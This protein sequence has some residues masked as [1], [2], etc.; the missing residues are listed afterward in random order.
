RTHI[1]GNAVSSLPSAFYCLFRS[2]LAV[3]VLFGFAFGGLTGGETHSKHTQDILFSIFCSLLLI[4]SY[5]LSR[6]SSDPTVLL[7][8]IKR[9]LLMNDIYAEGTNEAAEGEDE[10]SNGEDSEEDKSESAAHIDPLPKKLADTVTARLL[11]DAILCTFSAIVFLLLHVSGVFQT[12]QPDLSYVLWGTALLLGLLSH[13]LLPQLRKQLPWLCFAHPGLES[14]EYRH[15]E[16]S[17]PAQVMWFEKIY[18]WLKVLERNILYPLIFISGLTS[19]IELIKEV[20]PSHWGAL[21]LVICGLKAFRSAYS[22]PSR[23]YLVLLLTLLFFQYVPPDP[24]SSSLLLSFIH[25][26]RPFILSHFLMGILFSKL[27]EFYLKVQFVI[28]YIAPWQITWGSAFHAFAQPFS[29]PHS[30]MLFLQAGIS[31]L[32]STPLN[33]I[34]GSAIFITSY[35]RPVKF[36]ERNYNTK[37][38]DISNTRLSSYLERN[39]G[40]DDNNLNSIFY[41]HLTRSMQESLCGDLALGRWGTVNQGDCFVLASDYLNCLVH[42]IELGNGL[43]SFQVRGLEFRGT[44]CQQREV[45][46]ISEG[47]EEDVGCCCCEP[48][49]WPHMLS[50]NA[51]FSQRWLAWEVS[52]TKYIL[53]GYSISDNSAISI[54][55]VFDL[56]KVLISYYVKSIIFYTLRSPKLEEWLENPTICEALSSKADKNFIDLDPLFNVN[57]D[58]DYDFRVS[59]ITR[60]SFCYVYYDWI[61]YCAQMRDPPTLSHGKESKIPAGRRALGAASHNFLTSVEFFLYGLHALFKG[62]FRITSVND[63]W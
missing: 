41:E 22:D 26:S 53:E 15:F 55:Q 57:I 59:G 60:M 10:P 27:F 4:I 7:G 30:A 11:S 37:R 45:A 42:I 1:R 61:A 52:S 2:L 47:V 3:A 12:L 58:E 33:P 29:V 35:V 28:T 24:S 13:Y 31:S 25:P 38:V 21:L 16:V 6:S 39:P 44:Y 23:Q 8:I 50:V 56:R 49:H 18:L 51:A 19:D 40:L 46:A 36:W 62:D 9:Q 63:E 5:H 54:L 48:G 14:Y 32:L 20:M 34:L 43:V 17:Q